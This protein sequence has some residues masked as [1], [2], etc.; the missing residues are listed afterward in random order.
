MGLGDAIGKRI[1]NPLELLEPGDPRL[2][3]AGGDR[4]VKGKTG[5]RLCTEAG[6]LVLEAADLAAQLNAREALVA[7]HSKRRERVSIEQIRHKPDYKSKSHASPRSLAP[8]YE[9]QTRWK[10]C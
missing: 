1:A 2:G 8:Y 9:G 6:E 5:K 7:S 4:G 3:E 10:V